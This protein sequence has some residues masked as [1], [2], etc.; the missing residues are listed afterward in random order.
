MSF[1]EF[2]K[3]NTGD[4]LVSKIL[5]FIIHQIPLRTRDKVSSNIEKELYALLNSGKLDFPHV[6]NICD[7]YKV[8]SSLLKHYF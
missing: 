3:E 7:E 4:K 8:N 2:I 6:K 1:R 5:T